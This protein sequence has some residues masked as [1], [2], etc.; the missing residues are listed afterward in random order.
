MVNTNT[1]VS[2]MITDRFEELC[3]AGYFPEVGFKRE[4]TGC[5]LCTSYSMMEYSIQRSKLATL[6]NDQLMAGGYPWGIFS[7]RLRSEKF[8]SAA[9]SFTRRMTAEDIRAVTSRLK[10]WAD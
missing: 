2:R 4:D 1:A 10:T 7:T 3:L 8:L 5:G 6:V 9:R